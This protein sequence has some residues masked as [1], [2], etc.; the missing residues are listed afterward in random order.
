MVISR[1]GFSVIP[2]AKGDP[3]N[4]IPLF[5]GQPVGGVVHHPEAR[6]EFWTEALKQ[7][8]TN[9]LLA[10]HARNFIDCVKSRATPAADV[11]WGHR[12]ATACHLANISL[13]LGRKVRWDSEKEEIM[14]DPEAQSML[15]RPYRKPWDDA[16]A[17][18]RVT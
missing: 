5:L 4:Q 13:R 18:L 6:T 7:P 12:V 8:A 15:E 3:E 11:E 17:P 1:S 2:D 14:G 16:L 10:S 9:D